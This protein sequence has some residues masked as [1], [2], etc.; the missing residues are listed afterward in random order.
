MLN[1]FLFPNPQ[2]VNPI[3]V[4]CIYI[5]SKHC[6]QGVLFLSLNMVVF[7]Y[8]Y[9]VKVLQFVNKKGL[10]GW[11]NFRSFSLNSGAGQSEMLGTENIILI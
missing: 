8:F 9:F 5:V 3:G 10:G 2:C 1:G 6:T 4:D 7:F 11:V